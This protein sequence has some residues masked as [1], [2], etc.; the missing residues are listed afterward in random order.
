MNTNPFSDLILAISETLGEE[1]WITMY[2]NM[3]F[4]VGSEDGGAYSAF[5][6]TDKSD[7]ALSGTNWDLTIGAGAPGLSVRWENDEPVATYRQEEK[8]GF[9]RLAL[10]RDFHGRKK[11]YIEILEE[12]RLFHNLY[13]DSTCSK[14][15][16]FCE[17]GDEVEVVRVT[18]SEVQV[19]RRYLNSFMAAKQVNLLL[20]FETTRH[21]EAA[22]YFSDEQSTSSYCYRVYSGNSYA[23][24]FKSFSRI[25]GKKIIRC[26][27][28]ERCGEWPFTQ[29]KNHQEFIIGGDA[30]NAEMFTCNPDLLA[31]YFGAN[32]SAPL[33]QTPVFFRKSVMKKYY[34]SSEYEICDGQLSRPG[35][36]SLRLDNNAQTHVTVMLGDL[37]KDLPE[38]EQ[39]YWKSFN[40]TPEEKKISNTSFQRNILGNFFSAE[41]PEHEFKSVFAKLRASWTERYGWPLFLPLVENDQHYFHSIRSM[42]SDEQSEFDTLILALTKTTIDSINVKGLRGFLESGDS[43]TKSILLMEALL[44]KIGIAGVLNHVKLLRGIQSVRS[45]GVAHRKG[46]EYEKAIER[47]N[48]DSNNFQAEFDLILKGMISFLEDLE[49]SLGASSKPL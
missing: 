12:F 5:V 13:F 7:S 23:K 16:S 37:G 35:A 8:E 2:K 4:G 28:I 46:T 38:N 15:F 41:N 42:L 6:T 27:P 19:R 45:T 9:L 29:I 31:N 49:L 32:P 47:L 21:F 25:C 43:E 11:R 10:V 3:P 24:G 26:K 1:S 30:D 14:Y 17:S 22:S 39:L 18:E 44:N 36:W 40:T 20:F 48:I 34:D 33:Y